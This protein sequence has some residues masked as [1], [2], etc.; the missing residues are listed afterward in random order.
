MSMITPMIFSGIKFYVH[1]DYAVTKLV[2]KSKKHRKKRNYQLVKVFS[3]WSNIIKDDEVIFG[4]NGRYAMVNQ[5][6][7]NKLKHE[8]K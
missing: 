8:V 6:T 5:R 2:W 3:H 1:D 7:F 4:E